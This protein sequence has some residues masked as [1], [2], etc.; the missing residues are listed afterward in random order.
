MEGFITIN[1]G[2]KKFVKMI[3]QTNNGFELVIL[4]ENYLSE[5]LNLINTYKEKGYNISLLWTMK[6]K[7]NNYI[8]YK[9]C[10]FSTPEDNH[11]SFLGDPKKIIGKRIKVKC[12][13]NEFY[14]TSFLYKNEK[15]MKSYKT[16][17]DPL[18]LVR[19]MKISQLNLKSQENE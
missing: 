13:D 12:S 9:K 17:R 15:I 11:Y 10:K 4:S 1:S 14:S 2:N 6:F 8:L 18:T 16:Y 19:R 3:N 5:I 7:P